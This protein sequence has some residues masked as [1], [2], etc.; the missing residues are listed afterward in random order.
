MARELIAILRGVKPSEVC[1]ITQ[2]L[3]KSGINKIEVP[4]NSPEPFDSISLLCKQFGS[5]A[6]LGAGTVTTV[7][8]VKQLKEI[9]AKLVVSPICKT[10]VIQT[11]KSLDMISCPG[12][13]TPTEC[14]TALEAGADYL[15]IFP[16]S[17]VGINGIKAVRAVLPKEAKIIAVGG[18]AFD[19]FKQWAD[20]GA[21]GVGMGSELYKAGDSVDVVAKRAE[22]LVAAYDGAFV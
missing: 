8:Q 9:G 7:E 2:V 22:A 13:L 16:S 5:K 20:A 11:T 18:V 3:I 17:V 14:F 21:T 4:L 19:N 15:K 6:L 1:D 10:D 12:V